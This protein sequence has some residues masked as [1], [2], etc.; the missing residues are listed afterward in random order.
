MK[1]RSGFTWIDLVIVLSILVLIAAVS[2]PNLLASRKHG[3][4]ASAIGSLKS[5]ASAEAR[6]REGDKE[7]DGNL[8]YGMLSEL[9]ATG[10]VDQDLGSGTKKGYL[11]QATYS[12]STSE[13]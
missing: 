2:I 1:R 6:F 13:F 11:F 4:E 9:L 3:N 12:F 10:L 8:D 5:L 7:N